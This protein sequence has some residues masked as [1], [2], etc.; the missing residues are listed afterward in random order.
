MPYFMTTSYKSI[1]DIGED[2]YWDDNWGDDV[3]D[4][5]R[6]LKF[7]L[8]VNAKFFPQS[9]FLEHETAIIPN[10]FSIEFWFCTEVIKDAIEQL[11]PGRH[12][13]HPFSLRD[14]PEG[15]EIKQLYIINIVDPI[16]AVDVERSENLV[17]RI[18]PSGKPITQVATAYL[19]KNKRE[20]ALHDS[21]VE[22]RHLWVSPKAF[23]P[24]NAFV[25]DKLHDVIQQHDMTPSPLE[26]YR[27]K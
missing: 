25:S 11:E 12:R 9:G 2:K 20:I 5:I 8:E 13:F 19:S 1:P 22:D 4:F 27:T 16:D 26:F 24:G 6:P 10:L 7:G 15:K 3:D 18:N 21:L 23:G 14:A 17:T